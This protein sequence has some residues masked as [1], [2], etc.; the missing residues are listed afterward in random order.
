MSKKVIIIGSG[1]AGISTATNLAQ[2]GYDVT[3][4]EKNSIPGGR[5]RKF[6]TE[7]FTFD[8]GPSW[9][10][11][12]DVFDQYF[13][14]FGKK[15]SDYYTLKRLDPSYSIFF[16]ENDVMEV[17]AK[18]KELYAMFERYEKGSSKNLERFLREAKYKYEVGMKE[19]VQ[20]PGNSILEFADFRVVKSLFRLQMF[21]DMSSYVRKLFKNEQLLQLLEFPVLF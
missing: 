16:G 12:P 4:L 18:L 1:F 14:R 11:M 19:F 6:E 21:R 15:T 3:I 5:A 17:P 10:W 20:K 7:G 13:E 2:K 8:M 9:Y